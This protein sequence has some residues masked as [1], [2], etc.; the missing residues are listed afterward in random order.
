MLTCVAQWLVSS[1]DVGAVGFSAARACEIYVSSELRVAPVECDRR[2]SLGCGGSLKLVGADFRHF[3]L[4]F[5]GIEGSL[6]SAM[7]IRAAPFPPSINVY[8]RKADRF[9]G[10]VYKLR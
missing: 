2:V 6:G 5:D 4:Q 10:K 3:L 8:P 1:S 7:C 9:V